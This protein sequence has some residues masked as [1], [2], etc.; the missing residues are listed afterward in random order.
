[1]IES[2]IRDVF[3]SPSFCSSSS[4]SPATK[5]AFAVTSPI[6]AAIGMAFTR[7]EN[8]LVYIADF[9]SFSSQLYI[10]HSIWDW[11][12]DGGRE[13]SEIEL[14]AH[15][16]AVLAQIVG[17]GDELARFLTLPTTSRSIHRMTRQG[18]TE[19]ALT[20]EVAYRL[21]ESMSRRIV[22]LSFYGERIK[23][24]GLP[25]GEVS[26]IRQYE[27]FIEDCIERLRMIKMY[28]TP[29]GNTP[30]VSFSPQYNVTTTCI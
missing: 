18:R 1:M 17:T 30:T 26:R 7:R 23:A 14:R 27:R 21:L 25:S 4:S 12:E 2:Q 13:N 20:V 22:R 10:A 11:P 9:R 19:A 8:A 16:D 5:L 29:Q 3:D 28:R 6:A 15:C 24:A